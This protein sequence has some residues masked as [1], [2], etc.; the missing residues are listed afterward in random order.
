MFPRQTTKTTQV[1]LEEYKDL[2]ENTK[3]DLEN[4]LHDIGMRLQNLGT[5]GS[6]EI[7]LQAA[8]LQV[9]EDEKNS[10]QKSLE[11]C[12]QFLTLIEQSRSQLLY[13]DDHPSRL[14]HPTTSLASMNSRMARMSFLINS[15]G[16]VSAQKEVTSW[17]LKLLQHLIGIDVNIQGQQRCLPPGEEATLH[18]EE[19][20]FKEEMDG[21]KA[22]LEFCKQAEK[23]AN[24]QRTHYFEDVSTGNNSRQA[25]VTTLDDLIS[26]KRITSGDGSCQ[27]LGNMSDESIRC[28]FQHTGFASSS[29]SQGGLM[30]NPTQDD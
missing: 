28:F 15:E 26:A 27:A 14:L 17:K 12:E 20:K 13:A 8:E 10:T 3:C 4:H 7:R 9:M 21:T 18:P 16:L 6:S 30:R 25:I 1:V 5:Q 2:I 11:I 24:Q 29:N 19:Q 22:L 23:E